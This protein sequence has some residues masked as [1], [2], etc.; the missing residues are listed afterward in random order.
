[1]AIQ[2]HYT[3]DVGTTYKRALTRINPVRDRA[4]PVCSGNS[5]AIRKPIL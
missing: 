1:M 5:A 3:S 2:L 4:V